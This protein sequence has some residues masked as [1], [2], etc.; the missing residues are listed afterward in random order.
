MAEIIPG[1]RPWEVLS[2][3]QAMD[4]LTFNGEWYREPLGSFTTGPPYLEHWNRDVMVC[5]FHQSIFDSLFHLLKLISVFVFLLF[6]YRVIV[7]TCLTNYYFSVLFLS[8]VKSK[9]VFV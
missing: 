2:V 7:M 4:R 5:L 1:L 9:F 3:E 6:F 8:L